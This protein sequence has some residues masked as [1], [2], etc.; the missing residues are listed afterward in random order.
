MVHLMAAVCVVLAVWLVME[1]ESVAAR[2]ASAL[3]GWLE[4]E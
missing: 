2:I 4:K 1:R 3:T